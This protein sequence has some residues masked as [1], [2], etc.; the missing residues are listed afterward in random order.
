M[1]PLDGSSSAG[2]PLS[3]MR[4]RLSRNDSPKSVDKTAPTP[5]RAILFEALEPRVLLS[6]DLNPL[7]TTALTPTAVLAGADMIVAP[8]P[9]I[10]L[11][12]TA[13]TS[14]LNNAV[15]VIVRPPLPVL[16]T[17][18]VLQYSDQAPPPAP[19]PVLAPSP[20][21]TAAAPSQ[22]QTTSASSGPAPIQVEGSGPQAAPAING[23]IAVPGQTDQ[24]T[25]TLTGPTQIYFNSL[26]N[27][28]NIYWS[29]TGPEGSVVSSTAFAYSE[30]QYGS[31]SEIMQ[32]IA[33]NYTL[34]VNASGGNTGS[35][36]FRLI[37][38]STSTPLTPGVQ[39]S[40]TLTPGNDTYTY[41]FTGTAGQTVFMQ[42]NSGGNIYWRLVDP[43]DQLV[44]GN[45][46]GNQSF[47]LT[48]SGTYTVLVEGY[49]SNTA[50]QPFAF[51]VFEDV[52]TTAP[53]SFG[54]TVNGDITQPGLLNTYTFSVA[55]PTQAV[56]DSL[57]NDGNL[58]WTL[59]G[60]AGTVV[61]QR[62]FNNS[63]AGN[64]GGNT[65][66]DLVAGNYTLTV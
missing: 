54:Q 51:T 57:T 22:A 10:I 43:Y 4:R 17:V 32:L 9:P 60:P 12:Q 2:R 66:L 45:G 48:S 44:G 31:G 14:G 5:N 56:F 13:N 59:T 35:Y 3:W 46:F 29:L 53:L 1:A 8:V 21:V 7:N 49:T 47:T 55:A 40:D 39:V 16:P 26:T 38:L 25:F 6:A 27:T 41:Q 18:A 33:G 61:S 37:D 28:A 63:D 24:Y 50:P 30:A 64:Y 23:T 42:P 62:A 19:L 58:Y 20:V 36:G 15:P 34:S 52:N 65:Q 11:A